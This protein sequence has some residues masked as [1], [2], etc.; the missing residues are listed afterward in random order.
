MY[1]GGTVSNKGD[2]DKDMENRLSK[3]KNAFRKLKKVWSSKQFYKKNQDQV[4]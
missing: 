4:V 2:V 1:L 3:V